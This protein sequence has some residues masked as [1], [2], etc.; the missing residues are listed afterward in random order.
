[1][2]YQFNLA[3]ILEDTEVAAER[4]GGTVEERIAHRYIGVNVA[5]KVVCGVSV[6]N[7]PAGYKLNMIQQIEYL[8]G[9]GPPG[10]IER[11]GFGNICHDVGIAIRENRACG[12]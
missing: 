11:W 7:R 9:R 3:V 8:P 5:R 2:G 4:T 1:M 10:Y 6:V 12:T